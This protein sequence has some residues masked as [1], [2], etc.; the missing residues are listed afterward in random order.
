MIDIDTKKIRIKLV[1]SLIGKKDAHRRVIV[2]LGLK[3]LNSISVLTDTPSVSGMI[4]KVAY[5]IKVES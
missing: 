2:A 4:N 3:R 5:L 1:K